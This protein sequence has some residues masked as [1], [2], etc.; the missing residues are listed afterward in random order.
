MKDYVINDKNTEVP[1]MI[2][3]LTGTEKMVKEAPATTFTDKSVR[4][5]DVK[6]EI[7]PEFHSL[8]SNFGN[9][10]GTPVLLNTSFNRIG[11]AI[12]HTPEQALHDLKFSGLD[13]LVLE[14]YLVKK[15]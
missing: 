1:F 3:A 10:S 6:R 2:L 14:N 15:G 7:N 12:V 11:Q 8:I 9:V 5:Q 13:C 4:V